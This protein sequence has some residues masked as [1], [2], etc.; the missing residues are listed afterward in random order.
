MRFYGNI[1]ED[2]DSYKLHHYEMYP[3][4]TQRVYSYFEC[5][6]GSKYPEVKMFGLQPILHQLAQPITQ[7]ELNSAYSLSQEHGLPLNLEGWQY[8][9]NRYQGRLPLEIR[10]IPEGMVN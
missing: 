4:N 6:T 5:R 7:D 9:I 1:I 2:T 3:A 8:I 10:A